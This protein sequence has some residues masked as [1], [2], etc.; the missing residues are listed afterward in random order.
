MESTKSAKTLFEDR[1]KEKDIVR[2]SKTTQGDLK[3]HKDFGAIAEAVERVI[4]NLFT[5][6]KRL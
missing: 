6:R 4:L 3:T 2:I 1:Y 5:E